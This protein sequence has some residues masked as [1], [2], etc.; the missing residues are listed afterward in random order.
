MYGL[1]K[2]TLQHLTLPFCLRQI[3]TKRHACRPEILFRTSIREPA[4]RP[5][6]GVSSS[7][8]RNLH[9]WV[10]MAMEVQIGPRSYKGYRNRWGV[11]E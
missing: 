2:S 9:P 1:R 11:G 5:E 3:A 8:R 4:L 7:I 10:P 6:L